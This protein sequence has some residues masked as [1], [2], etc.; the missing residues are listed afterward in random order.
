MNIRIRIRYIK[1]NDI[2]KYM[3]IDKDTWLLPHFFYAT[4]QL[5]YRMC[6]CRRAVIK[7]VFFF[8]VITEHVYFF[9]WLSSLIFLSISTMIQ[10]ST[11]CYHLEFKFQSKEKKPIS[12]LPLWVKSIQNKTL[13]PTPHRKVNM[14]IHKV[15]QHIF[16][17]WYFFADWFKLEYLEQN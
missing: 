15:L 1:F 2:F 9:D 17:I 13:I 3:M 4:K 7:L 14:L 10:L 11:H 6:Y 5:W 8:F 16:E 12:N